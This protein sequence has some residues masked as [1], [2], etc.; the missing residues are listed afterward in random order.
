MTTVLNGGKKCDPNTSSRAK[1]SRKQFADR[2]IFVANRL[3]PFPGAAAGRS[4]G[5]D[6]KF[7]EP[8]GCARCAEGTHPIGWPRRRRRRG[9][10]RTPPRRRG[11]R[12]RS[13]GRRVSRHL[14]KRVHHRKGR[15]A[16]AQPS[17]AVVS[18]PFPPLLVG[19]SLSLALL[20]PSSFQ[21]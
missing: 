15:C 11:C 10:W 12:G 14:R 20:R 7:K 6:L 2:Q 9:G 21:E 17:H 16:A 5:S 1:S 18:L 3:P 8:P 19:F 13:I 4:R